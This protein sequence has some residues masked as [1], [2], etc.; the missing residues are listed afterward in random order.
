MGAIDLTSSDYWESSEIDLRLNPRRDF[1]VEGLVPFL[2]EDLRVEETVVMSTSGSTGEPKFVLLPKKALLASAKG[3][4]AHLALTS[5]DSW[6]A[7]LAD[8]HVGGFG[9]YARAYDTGAKVFEFEALPWSREGT[10]FVQALEDTGARWTSLT[11]THLH[12]LVVSSR[13][14][15][16]TLRGLLL[17]GGR[18]DAELVN[19]AIELGW[20]V[21]AS[22]G[23][24]EACSQIATGE[25]GEPQ[26]LP[27]LEA[28]ETRLNESGLLQI[29]G[30]PLFRGY[31][32]KEEGQ[33]IHDPAVDAEGWFTTGDRVELEHGNLR[34]LGRADDLVKILGELVSLSGVEDRLNGLVRSSGAE[35]VVLALPESR[36][37][38][39]LHA[40]IETPR[41]A[42]EFEKLF[43]STV[44]GLERP[45]QVVTCIELPRTAIGK[46]DRHA[47]RRALT[48]SS[49]EPL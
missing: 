1:D 21:R 7:G 23:M 36:K 28:W 13:R 34:H 29:R 49:P 5:E 27:I 48:D 8:F 46:V 14:A 42:S 41:E 39:S 17:G 12:D 33:W 25:P 40:V 45:E 44:P 15:P 10:P 20:P 19:D 24:T 9:I 2:K 37:G 30:E 3:V 22:Y 35:V 18:I 32:R 4:A 47:L 43:E 11:P 6:L 26:S 38:N 16:A 31:V